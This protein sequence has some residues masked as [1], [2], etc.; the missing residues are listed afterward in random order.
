MCRAAGLKLDSFSA[1]LR[2]RRRYHRGTESAPAQALS[3]FSELS[4]AAA[5]KRLAAM[6][7]GRRQAA[8]EGAKA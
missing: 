3:L 6:L 7:P 1:L 8:S 5:E 2:M 4:R